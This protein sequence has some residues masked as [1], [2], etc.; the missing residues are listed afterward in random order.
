MEIIDFYKG[1]ELGIEM[2]PLGLFAGFAYGIYTGIKGINIEKEMP[3][4][5]GA[6]VG[7]LGILSKYDTSFNEPFFKSCGLSLGIVFGSYF[8]NKVI[9]KIRSKQFSGKYL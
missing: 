3:I 1:I 6:I 8:G 2:F 5:A 9:S 4:C 7:T